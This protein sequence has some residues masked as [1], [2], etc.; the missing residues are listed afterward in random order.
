MKQT[1]II[2]P[3]RST[4]RDA[5]L[6]VIYNRSLKSPMRGVVSVIKVTVQSHGFDGYLGR[7]ANHPG[8][9]KEQVENERTAANLKTK[10]ELSLQHFLEA[11]AQQGGT[12][13]IIALLQEWNTADKRPMEISVSTTSLTSSTASPLTQL[14][15][16]NVG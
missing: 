16:T 11:K 9:V 5:H 14:V 2:D 3:I 10:E 6:E 15:S 7:C 4:G 8:L 13:D 12:M 1:Y